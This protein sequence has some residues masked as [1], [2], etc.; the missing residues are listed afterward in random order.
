MDPEVKL[1]HIAGNFLKLRGNT[2]ITPISKGL[3]N[4]TYLIQNEHIKTKYV[5]QK[6]NQNVF[7]EPEKVMKNLVRIVDHLAKK[8]DPRYK[9]LK[10]E[11][12]IVSG[13]YYLDE[14][15]DYWRVF[16][17]LDHTDTI[18]KVTDPIQ[19]REAARAYGNFIKRL[20]RLN[21]GE[22]FETIKNF[23]NYRDRIV[24]LEKAAAE[25]SSQRK[26]NCL[27]ELDFIGNRIKYIE[28]YYSLPL[29]KR[30]IHSDTKIDNILFDDQLEK[31]VCVIDLDIAMPGSLLY[32]YG[33]MVRSF[34]N[35]VKEDEGDMSKIGINQ[36]V[37]YNLTQGFI[38]ETAILMKNA[39][40]N[41]LL[42]GAKIVI[43][44]Q[45]IRNL[46]DYLFGDV[47]YKINYETHNLVRARNQIT[48]LSCIEK[49]E[50]IYE[51]IINSIVEKNT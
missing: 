51:N 2:L 43:L 24:K 48:L 19:A 14:Q 27:N 33:D 6:I 5:L 41:N 44:I 11:K 13:T 21:P 25:N 26:K 10:L 36:E 50:K 7:R 9:L 32:D 49:D 20:N 22:V 15:Q 37:F 46:T 34:T 38:E 23:H 17:Y 40:T 3:I 35:R 1:N 31:A 30:I 28:E 39:E 16:R 42:L 12:T 29:P 4:D 47:Y 18:D 8:P 45:A